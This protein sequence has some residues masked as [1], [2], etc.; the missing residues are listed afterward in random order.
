MYIHRDIIFLILEILNKIENFNV[1][2]N[3]I[4]TGFQ[5]SL[6]FRFVVQE[7]RSLCFCLTPTLFLVFPRILRKRYD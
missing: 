4:I 7:D 2:I 6:N 5:F 1:I 3:F